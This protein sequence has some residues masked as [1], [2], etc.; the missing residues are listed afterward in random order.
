MPR[1][2]TGGRQRGSQNKR[3]IEKTKSQAETAR[4][5]G[6]IMPDAF[7]GDAHSL[8]QATYKNPEFDLHARVDAA[9][10]ALPY[11]KHRLVQKDVNLKADVSESFAK[12]WGLISAGGA[13]AVADSLVEKPGQSAPLRD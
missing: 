8:L 12:L 11:E 5:I 9:K 7:I 13:A 3:T 2:K 6:E 1:A 4:L 10:A